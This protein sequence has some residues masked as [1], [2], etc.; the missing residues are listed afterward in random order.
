MPDEMNNAG[1][2]TSGKAGG[3]CKIFQGVLLLN[4]YLKIPPDS[5]RRET[6]EAVI[7]LR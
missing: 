2:E 6:F 7:P 3:A 1:N 4:Y 5:K